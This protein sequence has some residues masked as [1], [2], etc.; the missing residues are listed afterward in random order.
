MP[1]PDDLLATVEAADVLGVERSTVSRWVEKGRLVPAQ[2]LP[3]NTGAFLFKRSH[4]EDVK[5]TLD[6]A[7]AS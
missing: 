7:A 1:S 5:R 4:V 6:A 3:G 2:K